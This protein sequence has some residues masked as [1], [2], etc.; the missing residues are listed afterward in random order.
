M[1]MEVQA[2]HWGDEEMKEIFMKNAEEIVNE[3]L[4]KMTVPDWKVT[5]IDVEEKGGEDENDN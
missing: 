5:V 4:F 2:D 1:K 3:G